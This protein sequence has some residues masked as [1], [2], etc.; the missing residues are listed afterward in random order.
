M[1]NIWCFREL[2]KRFHIFGPK[3]RDKKDAVDKQDGYTNQATI[4]FVQILFLKIVKISAFKNKVIFLPCKSKYKKSR[5]KS[6]EK[7]PFFVV[8]AFLS[9]IETIL[10]IILLP[11]NKF[12]Y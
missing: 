1:I 11:F 3:W 9:N 12:M 6:M 7:H 4:N 10:E 5:Q 8:W 2:N